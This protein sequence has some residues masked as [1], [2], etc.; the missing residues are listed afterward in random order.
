MKTICRDCEF[1]HMLFSYLVRMD[2]KFTNEL[3]QLEENLQ[4][5]RGDPDTWL[6]LI[7]AYS[8]SETFDQIER[9]FYKVLEIFRG[10]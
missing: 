6:Q 3:L 9:D 10:T 8:A 4:F 2:G 5:R 1:I 7:L